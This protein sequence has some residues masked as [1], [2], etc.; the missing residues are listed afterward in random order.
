MMTE[1]FG[2]RETFQ[3]TKA[4]AASLSQMS[5]LLQGQVLPRLPKGAFHTNSPL[6]LEQRPMFTL[7]EVLLGI[8]P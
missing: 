2:F 7:E 6:K 1:E 5:V 4:N 3:I 8:K